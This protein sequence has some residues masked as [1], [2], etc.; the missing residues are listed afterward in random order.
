[1]VQRLDLV[2]LV[3]AANDHH[4]SEDLEIVDVPRV[5][6]EE[7]LHSEWFIRLNHNVDP[8]CRDI[9]PRKFIDDL[10]DL[11]DHDRIVKRGGL[12]NDRCI[13]GVRP[14]KEISLL[15][16]LFGAHENHIRNEVDQQ[17]R[18]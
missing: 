10:V 5:T 4:S 16:G 12:N 2:H 3:D 1:M 13:L 14:R 9:Y 7:R 6:C 11:H 8:G 15:V 17:P 18:V